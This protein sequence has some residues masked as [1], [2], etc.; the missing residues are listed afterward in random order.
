MIPTVTGLLVL[1][2]RKKSLP[3]EQNGARLRTAEQHRH[4]KKRVKQ[5]HYAVETIW[6]GLVISLSLRLIIAIFLAPSPVAE[7]GDRLEFNSELW[8]PKAVITAEASVLTSAWA[9]PGRICSLDSSE[10]SLSGGTATVLAVR[11][12]GVMLDWAGGKTSTGTGNCGDQSEVLVPD[13][14]YKKL[15]NTQ[16]IYGPAYRK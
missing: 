9:A 2:Y 16:I 3:P 8:K 1:R 5:L 14:E 13:T 4:H 11:P 10:M 12:D 15:L 6:L 7:V